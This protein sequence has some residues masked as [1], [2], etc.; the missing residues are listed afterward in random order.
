MG[1]LHLY[2][3]TSH[4]EWDDRLGA[5]LRSVGVLALD[6]LSTA[7]APQHEITVDEL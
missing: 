2:W 3:E 1:A 5:L 4:T 6:R 7:S